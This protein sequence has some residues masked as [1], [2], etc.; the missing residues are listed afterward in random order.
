[1]RA[2]LDEGMLEGFAGW[3]AQTHQA[4][5]SGHGRI[6]TRTVWVTTEVGHLGPLL[7]QWPGLAAIAM[8]ESRRTVLPQEPTT[9]R[10]Y[11]ILSRALSAAQLQATAR[12]HWGIE[13]KL[14]YVLDVSYGEDASRIQA[15]SATHFSRLRRLTMN[16]LRMEGS[17][18]DSIVGKRQRCGWSREYR[19]LALAAA[20]GLAADV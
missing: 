1:V 5:N 7:E 6:E 16:I 14:H 10:R 15:R 17:C 18:K 8:V 3:K 11:Y 4:T 9:S 12:G 19:L 20:L 2:L 13:N